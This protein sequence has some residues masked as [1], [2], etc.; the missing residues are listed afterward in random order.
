MEVDYGGTSGIFHLILQKK[1]VLY[2][3]SFLRKEVSSGGDAGQ[4][5]TVI[6]CVIVTSKL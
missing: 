2:P 4:S 1:I 3:T 5:V 6:F